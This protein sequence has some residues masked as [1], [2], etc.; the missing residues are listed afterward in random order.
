MR[1]YEHIEKALQ[2]WTNTESDLALIEG[3]CLSVCSAEKLEIQCQKIDDTEMASCESGFNVPSLQSD[4]DAMKILFVGD[5]PHHLLAKQ[6]LQEYS[7]NEWE[8]ILKVN[9]SV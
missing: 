1:Q 2:H 9:L 7:T 8:R 5:K 6:I 3:W 4:D